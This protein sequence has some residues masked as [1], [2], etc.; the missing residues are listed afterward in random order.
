LIAATTVAMTNDR[1]LWESDR[2][3]ALHRFDVLDSPREEA[4]DRIT[5]LIRSIFNVPVGIVSM[6]DGHRQWYK[7]VDGVGATEVPRNETFCQIPVQ[8]GMPLVLQD[9]A[10]DPR[11]AD[12]PHVT[13]GLK[14]RF[15]AGVPL[16]TA[17]GEVIGTLCAIDT[18][19]RDFS[20]RETEILE[21]LSRIAMSELELRQRASV[22]VLTG[23]LSRR[24]FKEE[25]M[26][27]IALAQRHGHQLCCITLDLDHFKSVNDQFG[28]GAGDRVLAAAIKACAGHLRQSD[29]I[30][31]LGGEEFAILLPYTELRSALEVAEKLRASLE[32]LNFEFDG[33][34]KSI[35]ASFGVAVL[36]VETPDVE[37]LLD[38]ADQALYEA[39]RTGRNR[40]VAYR[41]PLLPTASDVSA[42]VVSEALRPRR[43]L[44]AGQIVFNNSN[45]AID[46]TVR[47]LGSD[48]AGIDVSTSYGI[49]PLF[50]LAIRAD[51]FAA[52]CRVVRQTDKH[53]EVE[54]CK[55]A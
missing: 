34:A 22:D 26:R 30:G 1:D 14:V 24:A 28:H 2:L 25:G 4:F 50:T 16:R 52:V 43:V 12:H 31:R 35:T 40:S 27:S 45:S 5:R 19:P 23:S 55:A 49:P 44:K 6:M 8:T 37:T 29:L 11:F 41:D 54:F 21:D 3:A 18:Q 32:K 33:A 13:G 7:S 39:K 15:Y 53:L 36:D 20:A 42:V 46:C 9:A 17:D 48:R 38:H 10:L 47:T 51:G